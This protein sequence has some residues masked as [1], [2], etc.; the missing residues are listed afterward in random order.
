MLNDD[1]L[2]V[3]Y[4]ILKQAKKSGFFKHRNDS[5]FFFN[6]WFVLFVNHRYKNVEIW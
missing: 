5:Q 2:F 1:R 3:I 6:R 4:N